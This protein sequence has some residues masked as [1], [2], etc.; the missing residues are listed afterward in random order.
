MLEILRIAVYQIYFLDKIPSYAAVNESVE[1]TGRI[2]PKAR[3]FVNGVLR[4]ILRS[5][6][7]DEAFDFSSFSNEKEALSVRYSIPVWIIHK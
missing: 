1:I 5:K 3:G 6:E 2:K 7:T 4:N